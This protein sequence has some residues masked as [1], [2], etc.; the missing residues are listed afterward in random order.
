MIQTLSIQLKSHATNTLESKTQVRSKLDPGVTA[1]CAVTSEEQSKLYI[2]RVYVTFWKNV[3]IQNG[4][5]R[6]KDPEIEQQIR[7]TDCTK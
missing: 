6:Q 2:A 1:R 7:W 5:W 3:S 4:A